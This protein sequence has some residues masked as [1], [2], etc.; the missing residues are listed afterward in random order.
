[1]S[2]VLKLA[3]FVDHYSVPQMQ[4]R[5][6]R[7]HSELDAQGPPRPDLVAQLGFHDQFI[8]AALDDFQLPVDFAHG[9]RMADRAVI[10]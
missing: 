2:Q 3:Q 8:A 6:R 9:Q 4:I 5:G 7:V 10:C 1:M